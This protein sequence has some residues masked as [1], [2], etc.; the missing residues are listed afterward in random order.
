M[1]S[2]TSKISPNSP[3]IIFTDGPSSEIKNKFMAKLLLIISQEHN[4]PFEWQYFATSHGKGV[5]DGIHVGGAA[6]FSCASECYEQMS[7]CPSCTELKGFCKTGHQTD[8]KCPSHT[9]YR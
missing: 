9:Y 7:Q 6:K 2:L 8:A 4:E 3:I 1:Y 5:V